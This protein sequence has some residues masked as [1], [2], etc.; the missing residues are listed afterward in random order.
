MN[1]KVQVD[2]FFELGKRSKKEGTLSAGSMS[3]E[4][5]MSSEEPDSNICGQAKTESSNSQK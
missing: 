2:V 5:R 1:G 4:G 3:R